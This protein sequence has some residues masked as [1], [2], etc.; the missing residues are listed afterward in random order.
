MVLKDALK[1]SNV[2]SNGIPILVPGT[3]IIGVFS[4]GLSTDE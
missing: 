4:V 2:A 1:F 3:L